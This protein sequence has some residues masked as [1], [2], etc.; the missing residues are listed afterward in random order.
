MTK[1]EFSAAVARMREVPGGEVAVADWLGDR[2]RKPYRR[3][4]VRVWVERD[5]VLARVESLAEL[6]LEIGGYLGL[7]T[8]RHVEG[9]TIE[10][11]RSRDLEA[12]ECDAVARAAVDGHA[13]VDVALDAA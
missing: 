11:S 12:D 13:A 7:H 4:S 3:A 10:V 6:T 5:M 1:Q 2:Q 9:V 8:Y